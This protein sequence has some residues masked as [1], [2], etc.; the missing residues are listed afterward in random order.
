VELRVRPITAWPGPETPPEARRP[1]PF[2]APYS[3]TLEELDRELRHLGAERAVLELWCREDDVRLDGLLRA[4]RKVE[5]P[6]VVL[7]FDSR[8][9][10][11]RYPCDCFSANWKVDRAPWHANLRAVTL[12][13]E[14]LRRVERYGIASRAEQY[15]GWRALGAGIAIGQ[16]A[17]LRFGSLEEAARFLIRHGEN[18]RYDGPPENPRELIDGPLAEETRALYYRRA[19]M[20][21]H[22]DAGGDAEEFARLGEARRM[23]DLET[24]R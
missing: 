9:G 21:L 4:D 24:R 1:S 15:T 17:T 23:L 16:T 13:L 19:A 14:A 12:G 18:P 2:S 8:H 22:P 3:R 7:S 11:L 10:A 20:A 5:K 6:G